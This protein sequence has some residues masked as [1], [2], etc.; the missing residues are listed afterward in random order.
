TDL[1]KAEKILRQYKVEK[2]PVVRKDGTLIGLVTYRDILQVRSHPDAVKDAFGRLRVGAA[3]GITK[4]MLDRAA[5]LQNI[6][7]DVVCLDSAHGH[8]K[9]V[10]DALKS[11]KKTFKGLQV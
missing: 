6:G 9:G 1:K 7:V 2:L 4:D 3:L 11:V 8:T 10:I 5:A